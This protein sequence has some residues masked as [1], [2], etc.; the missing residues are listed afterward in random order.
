MLEAV[1]VTITVGQACTIHVWFG[2]EGH[3]VRI[4]E[5]VIPPLLCGAEAVDESMR[6]EERLEKVRKMKDALRNQQRM[7]KEDVVEMD[8]LWRS[9]KSMHTRQAS[10]RN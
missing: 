5:Y 9:P 4:A 6:K 8:W 2:G 1:V 10:W 7:G 3:L